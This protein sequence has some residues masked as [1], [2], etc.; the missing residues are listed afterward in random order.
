MIG[1]I[2]AIQASLLAL[3]LH[4]LCR[5]IR[6][7]QM[8]FKYQEYIDELMAQGLSMPVL[9]APKGMKAYRFVFSGDN[10]NNHKPVCVQKP[11]R[12][13]PDNE[14]F[15]G[16]ALSCF[17]SQQKAEQR[18]SSLCKSFKRVPKVI[19]DSLCGGFIQNED[20]MVTSPNVCSGHFDLY[21]SETCDLSKTF[22]IIEV[23]WKN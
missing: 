9:Y 21:E 4:N 14:K 6:Q 5:I 13:L 17:N 19:G 22:N 2:S 3:G 8:T 18:Y 16:Y 11:S 12:Q 1:C 15:S 10:T 23:L 7:E 20:G